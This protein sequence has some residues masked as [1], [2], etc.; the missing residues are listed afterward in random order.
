M[1]NGEQWLAGGKRCE[2]TVVPMR[3]WRRSMLFRD[4]QLP[5]V[6]TSPHIPRAET[7]FFYASTGIMGELHVVSE[8]VGYPLPFELVG[9]PDLPAHKFAA[10]LNRR[11]LPG[12]HFQPYYFRPYYGR[13]KG[14]T[15]G[16]ARVVLTEPGQARLTEIQFHAMEVARHLLPELKLFGGK[17]DAMF[18]KVCGTDEIRKRLV[19]KRPLDEVL[20]VWRSGLDDF[21]QRRMPYLLYE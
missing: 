13:L 19:A 2:L 7:A 17:R 21:H 11:A 12:V 10:E 20:V 1:I 3:G 8:G 4:T 9:H 5:W 15:C 6:P 14:Q 16:G 18:D